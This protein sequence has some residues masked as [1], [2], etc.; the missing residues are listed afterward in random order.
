MQPSSAA[1]DRARLPWLPSGIQ[2]RVAR[3]AV[4]S[5]L[6][7][8]RGPRGRSGGA[9][10]RGGSRRISRGVWTGGVRG[11]ERGGWAWGG[12][13][14]PRLTRILMTLCCLT[15]FRDQLDQNATE[16]LRVVN[17]VRL[18]LE[19]PVDHERFACAGSDF[20]RDI[21]CPRPMD[22][23]HFKAFYKTT[24]IAIFPSGQESF[25]FLDLIVTQK[26]QLKSMSMCAIYIVQLI[27]EMI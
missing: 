9:R 24:G 1:A 19:S 7:L 2:R 15:H 11:R 3:G 27:T 10:I 16:S 4:A 6:F 18:Q 8:L 13:T 25:D 23:S 26:W 14:L 12:K 17:I 21:N 5:L 20:L 22:F